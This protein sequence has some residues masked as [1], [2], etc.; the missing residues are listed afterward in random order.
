MFSAVSQDAILVKNNIYCILENNNVTTNIYQLIQIN[1]QNGREYAEILLHY[2]DIVKINTLEI[3]ILDHNLQKIRT[4]K[5]KEISDNKSYTGYFH[6]DNRYKLIRAIHNTY[7]Y[8]IELKYSTVKNEFVRINYWAPQAG[9]NINCH[10]SSFTLEV[11]RNDNINYKFYNFEPQETITETDKLKIY[12]WKIKNI[13]PIKNSEEFAPNSSSIY[14]H[15]IIQPVNFSYGGVSGSTESWQDLG[16]W[17]SH[18]LEGLDNLPQKEKQKVITLTADCKND[19]EKIEILYHYLQNNTRYVNISL[20]IGGFKPFD[21]AYV[22]K[23]KYGDC[24]A[25]SNY[26]KSLLQVVGI[27]SYYSKIYAGNNKL[28]IDTSYASLQFNHIVLMIPMEKDTLWLECTNQKMP[29]GYW[30]TMTNGKYALICDYNNSK[31]IKTPEF[32]NIQN[33]VKLNAEVTIA[34][35]KMIVASNRILCGSNFEDVYFR[36]DINNKEKILKNCNEILPYDNICV[37]KLEYLYQEETPYIITE[38]SEFNVNNHIQEFGNNIIL[39][40]FNKLFPNISSAKATRENDIFIK[41]NRQITDSVR[42]IFPEDFIAIDLPKSTS[43]ETIFGI[44]EQSYI[45][46]NHSLVIVSNLRLNKGLYSKQMYD[47]FRIF[48]SSIINIQNQ[49][50]LIEKK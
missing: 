48:I 6:T 49:K 11:A 45:N 35:N 21:A 47:E 13:E 27:K 14:P 20:D 38:V 5:S 32:N 1:N 42:Y 16:N 40:P 33:S 7:P 3:K 18:L 19:M 25:L 34:G 23:N 22:T 15:A 31:L 10:E 30:G 37:N 2:N 17:T 41:N 24:K 12:N 44:F 43:L 28:L 46:N 4:I 36:N 26:M 50:V 8:Y 29:F 9:W 39:D